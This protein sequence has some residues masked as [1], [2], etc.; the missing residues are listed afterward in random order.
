M[1]TDSN[2]ILSFFQIPNLFRFLEVIE[3]YYLNG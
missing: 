2:G 3:K 1:Y